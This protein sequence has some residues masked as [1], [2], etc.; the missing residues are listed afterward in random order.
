LT[1]RPNRCAAGEREGNT[2]PSQDEKRSAEHPEKGRVQPLGWG[3]AYFRRSLL[4]FYPL[5]R[6]SFI[7]ATDEITAD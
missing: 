3:A 2:S 7:R 1:H 5:R 4:A 6:L